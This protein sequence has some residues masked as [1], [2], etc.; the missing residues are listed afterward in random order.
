MP[1]NFVL[2]EGLVESLEKLEM[3]EDERISQQDNDPKH[4][5]KKI[6]QWFDDNNIQL[7]DWPPQSPDIN[8]LEH[9]WYHFKFQLQK[10]DT[11]P[12]GVK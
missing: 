12:R 8:S 7:L 11:P 2:E 10:S 5:S 1:F 9:L 3:D 4:T 6:Q